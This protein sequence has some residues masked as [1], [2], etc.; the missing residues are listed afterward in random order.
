[1][2]A[3]LLNIVQPDVAVF[4]E[5]DY[6]QLAV[7]RRMV[8]DLC[9]PVEIAALATVR[10]TDGL[11]MSSRNQYLTQAERAVA[12]VLYKVLHDVTLALR[13]GNRKYAELQQSAVQRLSDAGFRP[14]YVEIRH[15]VTLA[16]PAGDETKLVV[17]AAAWLGKARLIDNIG[18]DTRLPADRTV[19][20]S[21]AE[22]VG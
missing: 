4:G 17:L 22:S 2:V 6:Q 13:D 1:V 7:I 12:P 16:A 20:L 8:A 19:N 21:Q 5:K 14:E 9:L 10:E 18:V 11:A 3:K 15:A